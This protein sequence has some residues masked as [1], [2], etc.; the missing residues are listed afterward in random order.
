MLTEAA[1]Q[2]FPHAPFVDRRPK[3]QPAIRWSDG[4]KLVASIAVFFAL[5]FFIS[6][7]SV[8]GALYGIGLPSL[9]ACAALLALSQY[10][11]SVR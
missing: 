10:L 7:Q 1:S 11:S 6:P 4:A 2:T 9:V 8:G 5:L 3:L